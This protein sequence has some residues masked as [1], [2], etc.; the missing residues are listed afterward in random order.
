MISNRTLTLLII[1]VLALQVTSLFL[2]IEGQSFEVIQG[3]STSQ[4]ATVNM[5]FNLGATI[6]PL[7]DQIVSVGGQVDFF[8]NATSSNPLIFGDN[9]T[10]FE[11]NRTTGLVNFTAQQAD[12]G[13]HLIAIFI[14]QSS[15][16]GGE[17]Q[18]T[19]FFNLTILSAAGGWSNITPPSG[20]H[21]PL[22]CGT[23]G[24]PTN[25]SGKQCILDGDYNQ[26]TLAGDV[27][28]QGAN[29]GENVLKNIKH[30]IQVQFLNLTIAPTAT[31]SCLYEQSGSKG[32]KP[33]IFFT[34]NVTGL[35]LN[36]TNYFH[37]Y[38]IAFDDFINTTIFTNAIP[39]YIHNCS[40]F[41]SNGSTQF[42]Q[43]VSSRIYVHPSA[44]WTTTDLTNIITCEG[45]VGGA[46]LNNVQKCQRNP[47][48]NT[49]GGSDEYYYGFKQFGGGTIE[50]F[51]NDGSDNDVF[52]GTDSG[53]RSCQSFWENHVAP[54]FLPGND[55]GTR[56][57]Q[58][59]ITGN[60]NPFGF[61]AFTPDTDNLETVD[62]SGSNFDAIFTKN[63]DTEG[64]LRVRFK[65]DGDMEGKRYNFFVYNVPNVSTLG[66]IGNGPGINNG[67]LTAT[68]QSH[69]NYTVNF[70]CPAAD[71]VGTQK[72]DIVIIINFTDSSINESA[73]DL[74]FEVT[75]TLGTTSGVVGSTVFFDPVNAPTNLNESQFIVGVTS[76]NLCNDTANNDLDISG[77]YGIIN[78]SSPFNRIGF[79]RDCAD[80]DC[81]GFTGP[82]TGG[83]TG[84]CYYLNESINYPASCR[85][86]YDNDFNDDFQSDVNF[87]SSGTVYIDCHDIDCFGR[88]G[89]SG[90]S[91][92]NPCPTNE[93][94][95]ATWCGDGINNDFDYTGSTSSTGT[96]SSSNAFT[97]D[98]YGRVEPNGLKFLN[99]SRIVDIFD[100]GD[101]DCEGKDGNNT[102]GG[103]QT[104]QYGREE[105]CADGFNND[106]LQLFDCNVGS[107]V[108]S[109]TTAPS[110]EQHAEYDCANFC[111]DTLGNATETGTQC[112]DGI[113]NDFDFWS[114][115]TSA[116]A[117]YFGTENFTAG[118]TAGIDCRWTSHNPDYDCNGTILAQG[119]RCELATEL[120]CTD[121]FDNDFDQFS[122]NTGTG[123]EGNFDGFRTYN[124][125]ADCADYDCKLVKDDLGNFVDG[126]LG[127]TYACPTNERTLVNGVGLLN[128][129]TCFD[130]ID[131]DLDGSIDCADSDCEGA[132]NPSPGEGGLNSLASC[133]LIELNVT[134]LLDS[135]TST[136]SANL[137]GNLVDDENNPGSDNTADTTGTGYG[138]YTAITLNSFG[139]AISSVMDC[140]DNDCFRQFGSC[141][142]CSSS[143][144]ISWKAC[145]DNIDN[146]HDS[147]TITSDSDSECTGNILRNRQGYTFDN[148][149]PEN[150]R[151]QF[152]DNTAFAIVGNP[153]DECLDNNCTGLAFSPDGRTC[154]ALG[155]EL[156][157]DNFDNDNDGSI[158]CFETDCYASCGIVAYGGVGITKSPANS[159]VTVV[160]GL[161]I[162]TQRITRKGAD[163]VYTYAYTGTSNGESVTLELGD[164]LS[165]ALTFPITVFNM[166]AATI[167]SAN[168]EGFSLDTSQ[169]GSGFLTIT[170]LSDGN[171][172]STS[173]RIPVVGVG[174]LL[175]ETE[176]GYAATVGA[177]AGLGNA[178]IEVVNNVGPTIGGMRIEPGSG[179]MTRGDSLQIVGGNFT[180]VSGGQSNSGLAGNCFISINGPAASSSTATSCSAS[181]TLDTSGTYVVNITPTDNTQN[182]GTRIT[183]N[184]TVAIAPEVTSQISSLT[185]V[186]FSNDTRYDGFNETNV[187]GSN[188]ITAA[189]RTSKTGGE[190]Y[191]A[192]SCEAILRNRSAV[193]RTWTIPSSLS[194]G[195]SVV[196]CAVNESIPAAADGQ[197]LLSINATD[198]RGFEVQTTDHA[199]FICNNLSSAGPGFNCSLADFDTD[200]YTEG[201]NSRFKYAVGGFFVNRSC[202][203]CPGDTNTG[204]DSD[205]DGIDD[206]CDGPRVDLI[207]PGDLEN[208]TNL[209]VN[210]TCVS[211]SNSGLTNVSLLLNTTGPLTVNQTV[212]TSG[213]VNATT[214]NVNFTG[215]TS[216]SWTCLARDSANE[217]A[218]AVNRTV[219]V[220]PFPPVI[221]STDP[222]NNSVLAPVSNVPVSVVTN[223]QAICRYSTTNG[224]AFSAMQNFTTTNS[225]TH[226][227]TLPV[228]T[229]ANNLYVLC[230]DT[231]GNLMTQEYFFTFTVQAAGAPPS[232]S[233]GGGGS[234]GG[235]DCESIFDC[236]DWG[237]C[238]DAIQRRQ[239]TIERTCPG[240]VM[241]TQRLCISTE[242]D[243]TGAPPPHC[244]DGLQNRGETGV[245]C[246][247]NCGNICPTC[248][249]GRH[250]QG[251]KNVDCGGPC[252]P[253]IIEPNCDDLIRNQGE[254]GIDCG[255]PCPT[256]FPE[257]IELPRQVVRRYCVGDLFG[258]CVSTSLVMFISSLLGILLLELTKLKYVLA[259]KP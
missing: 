125:D 209:S 36:N 117:F 257:A 130:G 167:I 53:D 176:I 38:T 255:G 204:K 22:C 126:V 240:D 131:T 63:V 3:L 149:I 225:T 158:D 105:S 21:E 111:R 85:D 58:E 110:F 112:S 197:Y 239:C 27:Y 30:Q 139:S 148:A 215:A 35:S 252:P 62:L 121:N 242:E 119:F 228:T 153:D 42:F 109:N 89:S 175:N 224:T 50:A 232:S 91:I 247:G 186:H 194:D 57:V 24:N 154:G 156:C 19:E 60:V 98:S 216:A 243:D 12:I 246:G 151:N 161:S 187:T 235:T 10:I 127:G 178:T 147:G 13:Q 245:D 61:S 211:S 173:V 177:S 185:R 37:N 201:I 199:L 96:T 231:D 95:N 208:P 128:D 230:N 32:N 18:F 244:T 207:S 17:D 132:V 198:A 82:S 86:S 203:T 6:Q 99:S 68:L 135:N 237:P 241:P 123:W 55:F 190:T 222:I 256:C 59:F 51:C 254:A 80:P 180:G 159:T 234:G 70:A 181:F 165:P 122:S 94:S 54:P 146:D 100:C 65:S 253:C 144:V 29:S 9:T 179:L 163:F 162:T 81:Q 26:G 25:K 227:V 251:E 137:C 74:E 133:A 155:V 217:T 189:F 210:F 229:G 220:G 79:S 226:N 93:S 136:T 212:S 92:T 157:S 169:A 164:A 191:T 120:N 104:C 48:D 233:G 2:H 84:I 140:R 170:G 142:P 45:G 8:V 223:E 141:G 33:G 90:N 83:T 43:N 219:F 78:L 145:F 40:L 103:T 250:N 166:T 41:A 206:A 174:V 73:W 4:P 182:S 69:G 236:A 1:V 67:S 113:D 106:Q 138:S 188:S 202:D 193:I 49:T 52:N 34:E 160:S 64:N 14:N 101:P 75:Y 72:G 107:G 213:T 195:S 47:F 23:S 28:C 152:D 134:L 143:E 183:R 56:S 5:C 200:G 108:A 116:N 97:T 168:P 88:G 205:G 44:R 124:T 192:T 259:R 7:S 102:V 196:T 46:F 11:I 77:L 238:S 172:F 15:S 184:F 20:L 66:L 87:L 218:E 114:V 258:Y 71:C 171:G 16:C 221:I 76:T 115:D 248:T 214:F 150:C 39:W 249:D 118:G 31:L 129:S